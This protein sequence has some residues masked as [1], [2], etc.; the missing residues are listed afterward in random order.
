MS[1]TLNRAETVKP[2]IVLGSGTMA[3]TVRDMLESMSDPPYRLAGFSQNLGAG[4]EG[5][6]FED[7]R[8]YSLQ[9][10]ESL[11][12][13]HAALCVLGSVP[14][15]RKFVEQAEAI[16]FEFAT[17]A[18]PSCRI[19]KYATVGRGCYLRPDTLVMNHCRVGDHCSL[20]SR[21]TLTENV[22]VGEGSFISS[23]VT[24]AGSCE[25]G[26]GVF[27]GVG[28]VLSDH[29]KVGD[30]A[31]IGAGAVVIRDVP[32]GATV[33]GNPAREIRPKGP[34]FKENP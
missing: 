15:R 12:P 6:T 22:N 17:L 11:A 3:F 13:T 4:R 7:I 26:K 29:V 9:E 2:L 19:S 28:A 30:G 31:V 16:G 23:A 21:V 33:V 10:L 32:A 5:E 27:I 34:I 1:N 20:M 8:V 24:V 25:I 14:A 18:D